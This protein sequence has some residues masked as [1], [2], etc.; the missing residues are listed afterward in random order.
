MKKKT[1]RTWRRPLAGLLTL[2]MIV[3]LLAAA[4]LSASATEPGGPETEVTT[5]VPDPDGTGTV[6]EKEGTEESNEDSTVDDSASNTVTDSEEDKDTDAD[7]G[8]GTEGSATTEDSGEDKLDVDLDN[9]NSDEGSEEDADTAPDQSGA[10]M[11]SDE[12]SVEDTEEDSDQEST[13]DLETL[14]DETVETETNGIALFSEDDFESSEIPE[15]K[16]WD[17]SKSKSATELDENFESKVTLSLPSAEEELASDV[18]FVI[19][20]ST[21]STQ[22]N[23]ISD[24]IEAL[25]TQ[26]QGTDAKV[27]VGI[28]VFNKEDTVLVPLTELTEQSV[29]DIVYKV[30]NFNISGGTNMHAGL[31]AAKNMLEEDS[32]VDNS[33][34]YMILITDGITYIF[35]DENGAATGIYTTAYEANA[36]NVLI[37]YNMTADAWIQKY[38][39]G[40]SLKDITEKDNDVE[41][42][43]AFL[44]QVES[45][46]AKD[47]GKYYQPYDSGYYGNDNTLVLFNGETGEV[48]NEIIP[49]VTLVSNYSNLDEILDKDTFEK[50][51]GERAVQ[52]FAYD[53][54]NNVETALYLA[55]QTFEEMCSEYNCYVVKRVD[56][57]GNTVTNADYPWGA[58]FVN[59][60][61]AF[62]DNGDVSFEEIQKDLNYLVDSGSSVV[63]VIGYGVDENGNDYNFDFINDADKLTLTVGQEEYKAVELAADGTGTARYGFKSNGSDGYDYTVTYYANGQNGNS[64]ECFVWEIN[65]PV[66]NFA[67]VQ[68]TYAVKLTNPQTTPGTYGIYDERGEGNYAGLYT[69]NS[70][71]LYPVDS[72]KVPGEPETFAK[73]TV[74]YTVPESTTPTD[75]EPGNPDSSVDI[76]KTATDLVNDQTKVTLT[77]GADQETTGA[78]VVFVLDKS[79]STEVKKEALAM[80]DEL[81]KHTV[82]SNL[83]VKVGVITFNKVATNESFNL[84]LSELNQETYN[85]V[86]DIFDMELSNGTNIEAGIRAG[87]AMLDAD[88]SVFAAN[89]HLVLVTDGVSYLWGT[90]TPMTVYNQYTPKEG[91]SNI[92][93]SNSIASS[94]ANKDLY[95]ITQ[96]DYI[97]SFSDPVKWMENNASGIQD[98]LK[99]VTPYT[100]GVLPADT[101][102]PY[103][104]ES[105]LSSDNKGYISNDI[106]LYKAGQA[107]K[108]AVAKGYNLYCYVSEDYNKL[109]INEEGN[110]PWAVNFFSNFSAISGYSTSY[111]DTQNGVEGMFDNV[112]NTILYDIEKATVTDVIGSNFDLIDGANGIEMLIGGKPVNRYMDK[113]DKNVAHFGNSENDYQYTVTYYPNGKDGDTREL[114]VWEIN[115]PVVSGSSVQL[116]YSL[117]LV[118]KSSVEGSYTV[119]TNE[120]AT[121]IYTPTNGDPG[122][123]K[124]P[125]PTVTYTVSGSGTTTPSDPGS[126]SGGSS[127]SGS[128]SSSGSSSSP[129]QT[130]SAQTG[131]ETNILL[132]VVTLIVAAAALAAV[133]TVY[134]RKKRS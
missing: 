45:L 89:K 104:E 54:A 56:D 58:E 16:T 41:A 102:K 33:R 100:D 133:G 118:N 81:M 2:A 112:Q 110:Y 88:S 134:Y 49:E 119:P 99:Y 20:K 85:A 4:P 83:D 44:N 123:E 30:E 32:D 114:F 122:T 79:T 47:E 8:T 24:T 70:A 71:T 25:W 38:N 50:L 129:T 126:G 130:T 46:V 80:L 40:M 97:D 64:D 59:Y 27:K 127:G 57:N 95:N 39:Y 72:N 19:D 94:M 17:I 69:N 111:T 65:V 93:S 22:L 109:P 51:A 18:V 131:D 15:N 115:T 66:S 128:G 76:D 73:P 98:A 12:A 5:D 11:E 132:P 63:D 116:T 3:S 77:V 113:N 29:E 82:N 90:G 13:D 87:Q 75:P 26:V 124:F 67:P 61:Q 10:D 52:D 21:S 62:S 84:P 43:S 34:K 121:I 96:Q 74:S 23:G 103:I 101:T 125:Q 92:W 60:L 91:T 117:K 48:N 35:D 31:E 86:K 68:L 108:D 55:A 106:A 37:K 9:T 6:I 28:V 42:V 105:S 1:G 78:D 7:A 36:K 107:W 53:H 120:E 14:S